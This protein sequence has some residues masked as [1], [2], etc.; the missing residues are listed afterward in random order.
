L[1]VESARFWSYWGL[2]RG[3]HRGPVCCCI[4]LLPDV[5]IC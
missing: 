4:E 3:W 1:I 5:N 2:R